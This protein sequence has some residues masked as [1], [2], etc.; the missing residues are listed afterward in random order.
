MTP[1]QSRLARAGIGLGVR[2]TA[3]LAEVS[4]E[5]I[6]RI[7]KGE[8]VKAVTIDRV[9]A[10]YRFLGVIFIDDAEKPGLMVDLK[11][12]SDVRAG[13]YDAEFA[14]L[15]GGARIGRLT[16][17]G[18]FMRTVEARGAWSTKHDEKSVNQK[19]A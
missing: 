15:H 12:L 18:T 4:P 3:I 19:S 2:E 16:M 14:D 7:E 1:L 10:T 9:A 17:L 6:T 5:T 13:T 8:T 11:R